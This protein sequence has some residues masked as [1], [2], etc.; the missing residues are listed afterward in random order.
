[1]LEAGNQEKVFTPLIGKGVKFFIKGR[2]ADDILLCIKKDIKN[3]EDSKMRYQEIIDL[4][5]KADDAIDYKDFSKQ[6]L[7]SIKSTIKEVKNM[8]KAKLSDYIEERS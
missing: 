5:N 6:D 3:I 8:E 7:A 2:P 4:F 1:M